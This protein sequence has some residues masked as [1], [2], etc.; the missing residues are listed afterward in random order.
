MFRLLAWGA[1]LLIDVAILGMVLTSLFSN[2]VG[3]SW[4]WVGGISVIFA[5]LVIALVD[6]RRVTPTLRLWQAARHLCWLLP[7]IWFIG[8]LDLGRISGQESLSIIAVL[9]IGALNWAGLSQREM[10]HA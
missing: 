3:P 9:F 1:A 2:G 6:H 4:L 7:I 5:I 10:K 8:S